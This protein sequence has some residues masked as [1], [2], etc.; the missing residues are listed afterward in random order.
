MS[1]AS[2]FLPSLLMLTAAVGGAIALKLRRP[3]I[4]DLPLFTIA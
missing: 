3:L 4:L 1:S 2:Y